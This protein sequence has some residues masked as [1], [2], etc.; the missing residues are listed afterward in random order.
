MSDQSY[1]KNLLPNNSNAIADTLPT[2][3]T[4]ECLVVGDAT[5]ISAIVKLDMPNPQPK[6]E[7]VK[8]HDVW[9]ED[10]KEIDNK[11]MVEISIDDVLVRWKNN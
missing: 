11:G 6:S 2:L 1:I 5:P 9:K 7:N 10:W 4:G 3:G 8:V